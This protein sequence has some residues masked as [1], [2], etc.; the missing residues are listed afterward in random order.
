MRRTDRAVTDIREIEEII[1]TCK[2]CHVAMIDGTVPYVVPLNFGYELNERQ[3]TLYVHCAAEG[4]KIDVW[5]ANPLVCF[6]AVN[7]GEPLFPETP[8]NSGYYFSSVIGT[9]RIEAV[10]NAAEKC[11]ALA[12]LMKHQCGKDIAFTAAQAAAVAVYRIISAD[13]T[14]KRKS[15]PH[16]I[17]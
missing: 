3:L 17:R 8:C 7:E 6:D 4:R 11:R 13:Y 14:A 12:L 5:R 15:R 16:R 10:E 9:G 2:T 1:S